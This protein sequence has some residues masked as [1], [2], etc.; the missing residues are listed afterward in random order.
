MIYRVIRLGADAAASRAVERAAARLLDGELL[1]HPTST[2][3]GLGGLPRPDLDGEICRLKGREPGSP[4]IR[5]AA[6]VA[7]LRRALPDLNWGEAAERLAGAFWPGPLTMVLEDGS[8]QGL[9]VRV[10]PHPAVRTLLE[11]ADTLMTSTSINRSGESPVLRSL[12]VERVASSLPD[13]GVEVTFLDGG[14]LPSSPPSTIISLLGDE[15][16]ILREGAVGVARIEASLGGRL[17][18]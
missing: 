7:S 9:A 14:D 15:P 17:P 12:D 2:V 8:V 13:A 6:S 5:L 3:Y 18:T 10:D 16:R 4:L 11:E 1:I